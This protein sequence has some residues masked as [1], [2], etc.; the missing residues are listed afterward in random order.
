[1][2]SKEFVS[3]LK[4]YLE[5]ID[6]KKINYVVMDKIKEKLGLIKKEM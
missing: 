3:W 1:M 5:G 4:G 6:K 2:T